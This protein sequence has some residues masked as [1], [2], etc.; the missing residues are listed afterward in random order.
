MFSF[1]VWRVIRMGLRVKDQL[2]HTLWVPLTYGK[3]M[4]FESIRSWW[5]GVL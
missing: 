3:Y 5:D 4:V 2:V 1:G